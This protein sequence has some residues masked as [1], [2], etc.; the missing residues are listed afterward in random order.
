MRVTLVV[1][2]LGLAAGELRVGAVAVMIVMK[3][4][5]VDHRRYV[6]VLVL[7]RDYIHLWVVCIYYSAI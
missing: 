7:E 3:G 6:R 1:A 2:E 5:V 4:T